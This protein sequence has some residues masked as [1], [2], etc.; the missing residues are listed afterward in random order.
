LTLLLD[1]A[2][3]EEQQ[4]LGEMIKESGHVLLQV[5]NDILDYSKLESGVY[6]IDSDI[7]NIPDIVN[8]VVRA[9]QTILKS[10]VSL[11]TV[12][13][14]SLSGAVYTD[15]LRYRQIIQNLISNA[16]KFT[17]SGSIHVRTSVE[18]EDETSY[19]IRTEVSDSGIGISTVES[20]SLFTPFTQLDAS[21]RKRFRGTGLGLSISK[22][23]AE[24][25]GGAI[26]FHPNPNLHGSVFW[27]SIKAGKLFR[28]STIEDLEHSLTSTTVSTFD[29]RAVLKSIASSKRILLADD[30]VI[31]QKVLVMILKG[32]GFTSIDT[33]NNGAQALQLAKEHAL[34]YDLIIMDINM[35]VL[36]GIAATEEIRRAGLR[37]PIIAMTAN[38]LK[39][40]KDLYL[41]KGM[42]GYIAK[43][44]DRQLLTSVILKWLG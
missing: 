43:P 36:D 31:N 21:V 26:G 33:A 41:A 29:P 13:D 30:N 3:T 16:I 6:S 44:V 37:M 1:T 11:H 34:V 19:T 20:S 10:G 23:L 17:E 22:S 15:A 4:E 28:S 14:S 12:L 9:S 39:G 32:L 2:L 7:V 38:A 42:N 8:S 5:I 24:A 18:N 35:P 40:D 25:M 27:F